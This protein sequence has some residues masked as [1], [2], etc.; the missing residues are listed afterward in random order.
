MHYERETHTSSMKHQ[1]LNIKH[2]TSSI[3]PKSI[4]YR[5]TAYLKISFIIVYFSTLIIFLREVKHIYV[6]FLSRLKRDDKMFL[7][8]SKI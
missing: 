3:T 1:A 2:C 4:T 8:Q 5:D 6:K 7:Y